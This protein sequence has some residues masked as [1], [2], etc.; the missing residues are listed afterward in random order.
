MSCHESRPG[1][2]ENHCAPRAQRIAACKGVCH[3]SSNVLPENE[4]M[5]QAKT[6]DEL[7]HVFG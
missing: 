6:N 5:F 4:D 7:V 3:H 2:V 1:H